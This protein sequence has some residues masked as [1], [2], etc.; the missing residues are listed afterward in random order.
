MN[1]KA[2]REEVYHAIDT[3]R[4]YQDTK[5]GETLSGDRPGNGE[6]SVDEFALYIAG[7]TDDLVKNASHFGPDQ[8]KLDI[9][10][11][12]AG[13]CVAAMEQHGAPCRKFDLPTREQALKEADRIRSKLSSE[14]TTEGTL[15]AL[16]AILKESPD[17]EYCNP[18]TEIYSDSAYAGKTISCAGCGRVINPK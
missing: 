6:R 12:I 15:K 16:D 5:W 18:F 14:S 4:Y 17:C 2:S 10:R 11:K 3:E 1:I 7:Y 9:I 8:D 13:L